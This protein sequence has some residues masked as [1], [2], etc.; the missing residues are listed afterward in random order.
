MKIFAIG[1]LHLSFDERVQKPMNI[2]GARWEDHAQRLRENWIETVSEDDT[3]IICGDISWGLRLSEAEADFEWIRKL[4]GRKLIFKGNHDLWWNSAGK[5]NR[6]YGSEDFIFV[7]NNA[8][9][10]HIE[11]E[12]SG[13]GCTGEKEKTVAVCGSRGWV[14]PGSDG[15]SEED[16]KVYKRELLRLEMSLKEGAEMGADAMVGVLHFPPVNDKLQRSGFT[17]LLTK[18]D[19]RTCVYG[20]LHGSDAF[21]NGPRGIFNGVRY[22]LVSLD[23]LNARPKEVF[24]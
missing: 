6:L 14:C 7:Q 22:E 4:P 5:L 16:E 2:F 13:S 1:D 17:D 10:V 12:D 9:L 18:Y 24:I 3:V 23:Y 8:V 19:V 11:Q 15:F 20:H 21:K